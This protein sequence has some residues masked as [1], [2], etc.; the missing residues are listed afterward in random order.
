MPSGMPGAHQI[1][2]TFVFLMI[3]TVS[4]VA[5]FAKSHLKQLAL[6]CI[7]LGVGQSVF[8]SATDNMMA[9]AARG[10]E[11]YDF[12]EGTDKE[13][14]FDIFARSVY[15]DPNQ[16]FALPH[17]RN[18]TADPDLVVSALADGYRVL[19]HRDRAV[20]FLNENPQFEILEDVPLQGVPLQSIGLR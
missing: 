19:M 16:I 4:F 5:G 6:L 12:S 2:P 7:G 1:L 11:M 17:W 10:S 20:G 15:R 18:E 13:L 9:Q 8:L 3:C 14:I